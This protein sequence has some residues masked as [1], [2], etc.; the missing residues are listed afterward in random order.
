MSRL[1]SRS[2]L[3]IACAAVALGIQVLINLVASGAWPWQASVG[4]VVGAAA[5]GAGADEI[6]ERL[7]SAHQRF[8][9]GEL[10]PLQDDALTVERPEEKRQ[11]V[12]ALKGKYRRAK[13]V[14]L[15]GAGGYGKS[16]L[17]R[18]VCTDPDVR[19]KYSAVYRVHCGEDAVTD[20]AIAGMVNGF[21]DR[22]TG[23]LPA[24]TDPQTA[25]ELL[26]EI[27]RERGKILLLVDDVLD[28]AAGPALSH[29]GK[30]MHENRDDSYLGIAVRQRHP[31][32]GGAYVHFRIAGAFYTRAPSGRH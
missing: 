18:S 26:G 1:L 28:R 19:K 11:A 27:L 10:A 6:R 7:R 15:E 30:R 14:I 12:R 22:L 29:R 20:I 23:N 4:I 13:V 9:G 8:P 5:I 32:T 16:T 24:H 31:R 3:A 25:G 2:A 21:I 17:A